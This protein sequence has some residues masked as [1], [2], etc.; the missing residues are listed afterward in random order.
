MRW[1]AKMKRGDK[2]T[3]T[4]WR[5]RMS[6]ISNIELCAAFTLGFLLGYLACWLSM[7]YRKPKAESPEKTK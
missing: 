3:S 6:D 7:R 4:D 5:Y 1:S 2:T